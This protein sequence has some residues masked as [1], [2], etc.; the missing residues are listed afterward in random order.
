MATAA[1]GRTAVPNAADPLGGLASL[2]EMLGGTKT[3][4]N[5][6]DVT[7]LKQ[8]LAG[9]QGQDSEALLKSIFQQA[10][11]Q[12]PNLQSSMGRAIGARSGNNSALATALQN[13]LKDTTIAGQDQ[14]VKQQL[15]NLQAQTQ[16]GTAIAQATKGTTQQQGTNVGQAGKTLAILAG[17]NKLLGKNGSNLQD[18][19]KSLFGG[20]TGTAE[21][22]SAP[23]GNLQGAGTVGNVGAMAPANY[24]LSSAVAPLAIGSSFTG[25]DYSLPTTNI[26]SE[27]LQV[28]TQSSGNTNYDFGQGYDFTADYGFSS[29]GG[30]PGLA[31]PTFTDTGSY[32]YGSGYDFQPDYSLDFA[33]GGMVRSPKGKVKGYADGGTVRAGGSRR[34]ANPVVQLVSPEQEQARLAAQELAGAFGTQGGPVASSVSTIGSSDLANLLAASNGAINSG[35]DGTQSPGTPGAGGGLSPGMMSTAAG[36]NALSGLT[37][38]PSVP[39]LG[40]IAGLANA[41]SPEQALGVVGITAANMAAPGLGSLAAF[42]MNPSQVNAINLATT[43]NPTLAA[44]NAALG[45]GG[46]SIGAQALGTPQS[47]DPVTGMVTEATKGILGG[48]LGAGGQ[49]GGD[50]AMSSPVTGWGG[51]TETDLGLLGSDTS[52]GD[53]QSGGGGDRGPGGSSGDADAAAAGDTGPGS[54]AGGVFANGGTVD[55]KG[56]GTSDSIPARLSDG[57]FVMSADVVEALGEDFFNQLQAAFHTPAVVQKRTSGKR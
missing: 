53:G 44:V 51:V 3:T 47:V 13:L 36:L 29:G 55:G 7:A 25:A 45:L 22:T 43:L 34:S 56:T 35:G 28:P 1:T 39:G 15:A 20:I 5:A 37:G 40:A 4:T 18:T 50:P 33:D 38:G 54:G 57:E 27:G 42:G 9:L 10:S 6:G 2:A 32:D 21:P 19:A 46:T 11:Q 23:A 17:L 14:L 48:L 16:A 30:S 31:V 12:V 41:K 24:S 8:A 26:S 52:G 49:F